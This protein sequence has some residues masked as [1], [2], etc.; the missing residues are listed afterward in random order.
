MMLANR[1][2]ASTL[3][4]ELG[5]SIQART[6]QRV[7]DLAVEVLPDGVVI[8]GVTTSWYV[9]QVAQHCVSKALPRVGVRNAIRVDPSP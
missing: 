8:R 9:K 7:Q 4:E 2:D 3:A 1:T 6:G 5:R